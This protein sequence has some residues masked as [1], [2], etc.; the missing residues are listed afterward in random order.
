M[1][2][3]VLAQ[4]S[5]HDRERYDKYVAGFMDVLIKY[6]GRLL[7]AQERPEVVEGQWPY[8]KVILMSFKDHETFR[9]WADSP[10]YRHISQDRLA[11]TTGVVLLANGL[12]LPTNPPADQSA[13]Q[14]GAATG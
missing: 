7:A 14:P 12:D 6:R 13:D 5:I 3:Y 2:V 1:T 9:A 10:E 8:D 11:A 4:I